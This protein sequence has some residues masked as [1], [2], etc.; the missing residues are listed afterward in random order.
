LKKRKPLLLQAGVLTAAVSTPVDK[1]YTDA[2][3]LVASQRDYGVEIIGP[4]AQD[5]S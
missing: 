5:P 1:G 2:T 4:I 3:V